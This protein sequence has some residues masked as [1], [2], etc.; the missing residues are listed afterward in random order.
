MRKTSLEWRESP[1]VDPL[2]YFV[3]L[4]LAATYYPMGYAVQ[5]RTNS[6]DALQAAEK[7]WRRYPILSDS[8]PV[9]IRILV[10]SE[11]ADPLRGAHPPRGQGHLLS[12]VHG[13]HDFAI[14]DLR[15]GFAFCCLSEDTVA[16]HSYFRYYFLEPLTYVMQAARHF[17]FVH[18][19]CISRDGRAILLC[20]DS[21]S[22]KT[23][24]AYACAKRGWDFL[25]GDAVHIVRQNHDRMVIGRPYEIRFR[26]SARNLFPELYGSSLEQRANGVVDLE[27]DTSE[28]GIPTALQSCA[29]QIVFLERSHVTTLES[30]PVDEAMRQLEKTICFGDE[31]SRHEQRESLHY[32]ASLPML[33]L[34]YSDLDAAERTLASLPAS[35]SL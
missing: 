22:G 25:S 13:P 17:V 3:D 20:G 35:T 11:P 10:S 19:S 12:I 31:R 28:L 8:E 23:C 34:T 32:F 29:E 26:E 24:L 1:E 15:S 33:K 4:P 27:V 2:R 30:F 18:A 7:L 9:H 16:N 14:A 21:G 6:R 5:I